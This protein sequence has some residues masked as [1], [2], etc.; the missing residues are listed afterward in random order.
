MKFKGFLTLHHLVRDPAINYTSY[1][2]FHLPGIAHRALE[3][4]KL[5][6]FVI[7]KDTILLCSLY[8]L[9]MDVDYWIDPFVFRPERF[10]DELGNLIMHE[11]FMPFGMGKRRC[12]GESL[13]K[14]SLFLF[15]ASFL[16]AFDIEPTEGETLPDLLGSDGITLSPN[17]YKVLVTKR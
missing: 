4:A 8:S 5:G 16:H 14:S 10:I 11:N 3:D 15:F 7:P 6:E 1:L 13:A 17:P 2:T 12:I 9:H